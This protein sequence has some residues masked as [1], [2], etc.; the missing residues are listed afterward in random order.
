MI[1]R[2][3]LLAEDQEL[4]LKTVATFFRGRWADRPMRGS[5]C[6]DASLAAWATEP[7]HRQGQRQGQRLLQM[8]RWLPCV[9]G[10]LLLLAAVGCS[11]PQKKVGDHDP[12]TPVELVVSYHAGSPLSGPANESLQLPADTATDVYL[13]QVM[14]WIFMRS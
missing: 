11:N 5:H 10:A 7:V 13:V 4:S 6:D 2:V 1:S 9:L 14:A 8:R 3:M 12:Q